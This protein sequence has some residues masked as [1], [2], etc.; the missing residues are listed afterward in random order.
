MITERDQIQ[1]TLDEVKTLKGL[2]PICANCKQIRDDQGF[3]N[4]MESYIR[5]HSEAEFSHGI[6]P[7]CMAKLYPEL[8]DEY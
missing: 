5:Q 6:C 7:E 4:Q 3:W 2:I 1:K 8:K